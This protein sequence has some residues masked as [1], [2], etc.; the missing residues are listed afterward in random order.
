MLCNW[1]NIRQPCKSQDRNP[2]TETAKPALLTMQTQTLQSTVQNLPRSRTDGLLSWRQISDVNT[3]LCYHHALGMQEI[4]FYRCVT[5]C[6]KLD[7][8]SHSSHVSSRVC[9]P[10]VR[11]GWVLHGCHQGAG[12]PPSSLEA[13]AENWPQVVGQFRFFVVGEL[14]ASLAVSQGVALISRRP[15]TSLPRGPFHL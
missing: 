11:F 3:L 10:G 14:G 13:L 7:G 4:V 2:V 1:W 15:P 6:H 9:G 12:Q 8:L 5:K